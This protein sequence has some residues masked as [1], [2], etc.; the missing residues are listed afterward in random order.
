M[1][2]ASPS[3]SAPGVCIGAAGM[4]LFCMLRMRPAFTASKKDSRSCFGTCMGPETLKSKLPAS[5]EPHWLH[6]MHLHTQPSCR[7]PLHCRQMSRS[8]S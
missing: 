1:L 5:Q 2:K 6:W 3:S 4:S 8:C 7:T